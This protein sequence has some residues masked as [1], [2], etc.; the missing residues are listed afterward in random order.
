MIKDKVQADGPAVALSVMVVAEGDGRGLEDLLNSY[1]AVLDARKESYEILV[2]FDHQG[3]E[4]RK[5]VEGLKGDWLSLV[6][7][8]LRPWNGE[9]AAIK[10]G[11][12]RARAEIILSLPGWPEIDP[13]AIDE[14]IAAAASSDMAIARRTDREMSG[15]QKFRA[16]LTNGLLRLLFQRNID[17]VFC[18]SRAGKREVFQSI[19]ELGV[20]QHFMPVIAV[21]EGYQVHQ[22]DVTSVKNP[23]VPVVYKFKAQGHLGALVDMLTLYVGLKFLKRPLRFFGSIGLPLLVVGGL[24]TLWLVI[25]RLLGAPLAD[26]PA[27]VFSILMMVLGVQILALGLVGEII[28]FS[29]SRRMRNYEIEKIIRG[30]LVDPSDPM[31]KGDEA[32]APPEKDD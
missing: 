14:L 16:G 28:I 21:N 2:L 8:P 11:I 27:L 4:I 6:D 15:M 25:E 10:L 29:S 1:R 9:D 31:A 18:R 17:D 22:I 32:T 20:R 23:S 13:A 3:E 24:I 19:S 26:R 12:G 30:R 7:V 5:V